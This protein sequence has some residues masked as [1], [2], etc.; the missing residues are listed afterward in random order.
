MQ[1]HVNVPIRSV[2]EGSLACRLDTV[3]E[4]IDNRGCSCCGQDS[5]TNRLDKLCQSS[6]T[7]PPPPP[8]PLPPPS[9]NKTRAAG[10]GVGGGGGGGGGAGCGGDGAIACC[11]KPDRKSVLI[12]VI[13][14]LTSPSPSPASPSSFIVVSHWGTLGLCPPGNASLST[15]YDQIVQAAESKVW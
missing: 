5:Y 1:Q 2:P 7:S 11:R 12:P 6:H 3:E 4:A 10:G 14:T 8:L 15:L 9:V 13:K